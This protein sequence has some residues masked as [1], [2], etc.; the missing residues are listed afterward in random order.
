MQYVHVIHTAA[1]SY[2]WESVTY[3]D[4]MFRHLMAAKPWRSW[5]KTYNQGW[6]LALKH[7]F[8]NTSHAHQNGHRTNNSLKQRKSWKDECCWKFNKNKCSKG[9]CCK[10]AHRCTYCG[11]WNHSFY[12]C[13]KRKNKAENR[14]DIPGGNS[15]KTHP[16]Q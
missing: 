12:N 10:Y 7:D 4:F 9:N 13:R 15:Q 5:A 8:N 1:A 3:Y 11:A 6:N 2:N 16:N 14:N